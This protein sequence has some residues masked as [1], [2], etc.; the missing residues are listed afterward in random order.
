MPFKGGSD[1]KRGD[2]LFEIDPRPYQAQFDHQG[3]VVLDKA[4]LD[5]ARTT[6]ARYQGAGPDH[7]RRQRASLGQQY[8]T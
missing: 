8:V 2:L 6:L 5:L 7:A 1:V 3:Q 4:E